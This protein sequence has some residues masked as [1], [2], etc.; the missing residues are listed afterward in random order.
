MRRAVV[1][2]C[3]LGLVFVGGASGVESTIYPG[4]GIGINPVSPPAPRP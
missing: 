2:V 4:V 1:I 3:A